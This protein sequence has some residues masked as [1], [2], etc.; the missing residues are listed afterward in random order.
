MN[1]DVKLAGQ[2]EQYAAS[3]DRTIAGG[4]ASQA[5]FIARALA[6]LAREAAA[7][8]REFAQLPADRLPPPPIVGTKVAPMP[9]GAFEATLEPLDDL[10]AKNRLGP[11]GSDAQLPK[12]KRAA[13]PRHRIFTDPRLEPKK[14][15]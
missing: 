8:L 12:P 1:Y 11:R 14:G 7:R 4:D 10:R 2:L 6:D 5:R 13:A 9:R 3:T 15:R